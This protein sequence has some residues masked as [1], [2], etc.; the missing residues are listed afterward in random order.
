MAK[1]L[2]AADRVLLLLSLVPYLREHGPTPVAELARTFEVDPA[3]LRGLVTFLATAGIPGETLAYQHDD[4]FDIDWDEFE[5]RDVVALTHTVA[6]EEA[7]RFTGAETA[8]LLAGLHALRPLLASDDALLAE[9]L[10]ARLAE[11]MS[12][13]GTLATASAVSVADVGADERL[14]ALLAAIEARRSVRMRYRDAEGR[15]SLRTVDPTAL[16]EREGVWY[17]R[18]FNHERSAERTFRVALMHDLEVLG[19]FVERP[20]ARRSEMRETT[21]I[22]AVVPARLLPVLRGFAPETVDDLGDGRVRISIEAW[23]PGAAVRLVQHRPGEI[24]IV[25]PPAARAAAAEWAEAALSAY[26]E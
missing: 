16:F 26:G 25:A 3:T 23:H 6:I 7:P 21:E 9:R 22:V 1:S 15:E 14:R 11:A 4:L 5:E 12:A 18:G 2:L 17:L 20:E 24:E 10:A 8:A 13:A 19:E